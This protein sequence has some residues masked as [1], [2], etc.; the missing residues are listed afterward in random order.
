MWL[1]SN[2]RL[3]DM[4]EGRHE[5]NGVRVQIA[6]PDLIVKK[7][8]LNKWVNR[9]PKSPLEKF[10]K[11]D[12]LIGAGIWVAFPIRCPPAAELLVV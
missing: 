7:Q 2:K 1:N 8:P 9:H 6:D 4:N 5:Q 12:N 10:R 3:T 11:N